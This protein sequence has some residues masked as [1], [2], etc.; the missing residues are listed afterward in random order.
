MTKYFIDSD[1][2]YIGGFEGAD[3]PEGSIEVPNAPDHA[4]DKWN[5][6]AWIPY[7]PTVSPI[8]QLTAAVK[9]LPVAKRTD[10]TWGLFISQCLTALNPPDGYPDMEAVS[11]L[12]INFQTTDSDYLV[13]I[14]QAKQLFGLGGV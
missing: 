5:G 4:L 10:T 7:T 13:I 11:Y 6:S 2:N 3:P 9:A 14:N 8:D 1:G 12:I